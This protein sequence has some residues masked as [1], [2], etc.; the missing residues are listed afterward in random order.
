MTIDTTSLFT[1]L[2]RFGLPTVYLGVL[3]WLAWRIITGPLMVLAR[4]GVEYLQGA[5]ASLNRTHVEHVELKAHVSAESAA[6]REHVT[7]AVAS[8]RDRVSVAEDRIEKTGRIPTGEHPAYSGQPPSR[9]AT[10]T[11]PGA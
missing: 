7:T 3:A 11:L 10:P 6:T 2:D 1:F 9:S 8:V 5:T 4:A